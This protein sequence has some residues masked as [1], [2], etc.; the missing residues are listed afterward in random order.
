MVSVGPLPT[1][2]NNLLF[3]LLLSFSLQQV[4]I[5]L[6]QGPEGPAGCKLQQTNNNVGT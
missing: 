5:G 1:P 6:S 3:L 2:G 4:P